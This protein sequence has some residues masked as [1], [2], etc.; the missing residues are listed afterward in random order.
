M[1]RPAFAVRIA[2][3]EPS[4]LERLP[5]HL[6]ETPEFP[7]TLRDLHLAPRVH[8][9]IRVLPV[10]LLVLLVHPEIPGILRRFPALEKIPYVIAPFN[11]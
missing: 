9:E 5:V 1:C 2:V 10:L 3:E 7:G 4:V 8:P 6:P 11:E